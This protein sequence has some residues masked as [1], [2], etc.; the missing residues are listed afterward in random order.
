MRSR[1]VSTHPMAGTEYSGPWAAV[2]GLFDGR[3]CIICNRDESDPD[4]AAAVEN[5]YDVL[6]MR[7]IDMDASNHDV[8][9]AYVS[10]ISHITSFA[11][12]LTVLDKEKNEKHIFDLAS[13]GFSSTVRLA[14]S[15]ADMWVPI[16]SQNRDNVVKV[17]DTYLERMKDFRNAIADGDEDSVRSLIEE[18]NRIKRII[19]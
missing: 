1:Y 16:F 15:S 14:K 4:A 11:L 7:Q 9:T 2:P 17:I 3:A 13:G 12:A 8:H 5:L 6:N 19:R 18:A 10:H